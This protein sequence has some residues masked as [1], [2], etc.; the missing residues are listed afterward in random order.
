MLDLT[1]A[2]AVSITDNYQVLA[3]VGS[4]S[5]HHVIKA[6]PETGLTKKVLESGKI[7]VARS[8]KE[9]SLYS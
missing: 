8:K 5:D 4:A 2:D 7:S 9:I 1:N 6:K 3:H